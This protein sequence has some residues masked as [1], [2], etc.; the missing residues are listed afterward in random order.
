MPVQLETGQIAEGANSL[1]RFPP[2]FLWGSGT[3]AYQVEGQNLASD[4][5]DWERRGGKIKNGDTSRIACDWWRGRYREDFT[6]ARALGQ[7][8]HRLSVEWGRLEPREGEWDRAAFGVYRDMLTRL[9][10]L[11]L[12]PLVTLHHFTSPRW[13]TARGGWANGAAIPA[14]RRFAERVV[15]ELGDLCDFWLTFNEPNTLATLSYGAGMWPPEKKSLANALRVMVNLVRAHAA[16]Y[17]AIKA[18]QR[19][20]R[21]GLAHA[22]RVITPNDP[23]SRLDRLAAGLRDRLFNRLFLRALEEGVL[24]FPGGAAISVPEAQGTQDFVG[25][26]YYFSEGAAFDLREPGL[27]FGRR[28]FSA[29]ACLWQSIYLGAANVDPSSFECL[30]KELALYRKPIYVTEN[31]MFEAK[32]ADQCEYLVTHL[33][34]VHRAMEAGADVRGY[35]WWTLVD[36]FEWTEGYGPRFGLFRVDRSTQQ[37]TARPVAALYAQIARANALLAA[38]PMRHA[39]QRGRDPE[40]RHEQPALVSAKRGR[41]HVLYERPDAAR[42]GGKAKENDSSCSSPRRKIQRTAAGAVMRPGSRSRTRSRQRRTEH[43]ASGT[44]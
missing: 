7:N 8:T 37:R 3:A 5:W 6:R 25:V 4:W 40:E 17:A 30:L 33:A 26:N 34:A 11:G 21:I 10:D 27:L 36:S 19:D 24:R 38:P 32:G 23:I 14:F 2:G 42:L 1:M 39:P 44:F 22:F 16:A 35:Y 18:A 9:R 29:Q 41:K 43:R 12:V 31:G 20:A 15:R 13:L 28:V